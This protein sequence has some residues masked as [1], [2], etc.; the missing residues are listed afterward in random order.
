MTPIKVVLSLVMALALAGCVTTTSSPF[1]E[2]KDIDKA[3]DTYV[4][5]GYRHFE[6]DNLFQAKQ[7]LSRAMELD[8]NNPG[9][10]LGLARVFDVEEDDELAEHH[11]KKAIRHGGKTEARF[12][13]GVFLYNHKRYEDAFDEFGE[14]TEDNFYARRALSFEF[15]ALSAR[16]LDKTDAAIKAYERA[17][18]LDR[19]LT[20][21]Y[22]GLAE[23]REQK[24][25]SAKAFDAYRGFISLVRANRANHSA[26]TLW[27]GIRIAHQVSNEN[28]LSSLAL[29]LRNRFPNTEEY[30]LYREWKQNEGA[31]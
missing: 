25:D 2:K 30:R 18:V 31:A 26:H 16:R 9:A 27:L 1:A 20:N 28:L 23:L 14:V 11:F 13:Y 3:V 12:Q 6:N 7:A 10:H 22:I 15:L 17:I 8:K 19:L 24:G 5:I 21:S 4:Q 29:Q